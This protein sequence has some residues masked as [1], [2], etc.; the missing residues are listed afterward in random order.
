[1]QRGANVDGGRWKCCQPRPDLLRVYPQGGTPSGQSRTHSHMAPASGAVLWQADRV[2]RSLHVSAG[3]TRTLPYGDRGDRRTGIRRGRGGGGAAS[4]RA[5][6]RPT[7]AYR[8]IA[9]TPVRAMAHVAAE[10]LR[11]ARRAARYT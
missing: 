8:A 1:M 7:G 10:P 5:G 2:P 4:P 11:I 6:P 3:R 9:P